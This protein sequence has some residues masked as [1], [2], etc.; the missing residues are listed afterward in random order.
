MHTPLSCF[1]EGGDCTASD[2]CGAGP[3][4]G[5]TSLS[6]SVSLSPESLDSLPDDDSSSFTSCLP[7]S[8]VNGARCAY[9]ASCVRPPAPASDAP[10]P[11][12]PLPA[13]P[14]LPRRPRPLEACGSISPRAI[15]SCL[16]FSY[17]KNPNQRATH[18]TRKRYG[19]HLFFDTRRCGPTSA[20]L[21]DPFCDI[22]LRLQTDRRSRNRR[23]RTR[24]RH[25]SAIHPN[26]SIA[27]VKH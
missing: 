4:S 14:P 18:V 26:S 1:I 5:V 10:R 22:F 21:G 20:P 23:S 19:L 6:S 24:A 27:T 12:P 8:L 2:C 7:S 11:L 16:S 9:P 25:T 13:L 15:F 3:V 17:G